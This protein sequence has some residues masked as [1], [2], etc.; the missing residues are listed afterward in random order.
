M[1]NNSPD[2]GHSNELRVD[3]AVIVVQLTFVGVLY[4]AGQSNVVLQ[5]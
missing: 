4:S 1:N 3:P 2:S 5:P